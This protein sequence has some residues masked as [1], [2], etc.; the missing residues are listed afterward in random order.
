MVSVSVPSTVVAA[1]ADATTSGDVER[2]RWAVPFVVIGS[3][4]VVAGGLVAAVTGP[5]G[6]GHG[7]WLA[8]F[9][10]L[11]GGVALVALGAGQAWLAAE[12]PSDTML[13]LELGLWNAGVVATIVGT[14]VGAPGL[15]TIGGLG[16]VAAL[17]VFLRAVW[18]RSASAP[19]WAWR[20]YLA[21][22]GV[23]LVSTPVGLLLAW[24][25]A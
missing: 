11:V 22:V 1:D 5:T 7:S 12:R 21:G 13:R 2:W 25:R 10:V 15:T 9:L 4:A 14:L 16:T 24:I 17:G 8:A 6:F 23:L 20:S 18:R 3:V 19:L